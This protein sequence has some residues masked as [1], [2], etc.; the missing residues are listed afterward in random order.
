MLKLLTAGQRHE[1]DILNNIKPHKDIMKL[2][3]YPFYMSNL[4]YDLE[5]PV[6]NR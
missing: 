3:N 5:I 2:N 1:I 4:Q 6:D